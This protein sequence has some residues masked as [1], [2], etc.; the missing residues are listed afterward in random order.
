MTD[1]QV[2]DN[3][4]LWKRVEKTSP[5]STKAAKVNGMQITV[6]DGY[7]MIRKA[8]EQFGPLGIGWGYEVLEE[9]WDEGAPFALKQED[10]T[11]YQVIA[12][13]HTIKLLLWYKHDGQRGEVTQYGHTQALYRSKWGATDDGEA[14]K[15]SLMDAIKKSLSMLGFSADVFTGQFDDAEYREQLLTEEAIDKAEDKEAEIEAK[16]AELTEYVKRN[17]EAINKAVSKPEVAGVVKVSV[18]HLERQKMIPC[19]QQIADRGIKA[20]TRDSQAKLET[21]KDA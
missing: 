20:I 9:R 3:L 11:A 14:P 5:G 15:K 17:I 12:R 6:I 8:T 2:V 21:F 4:A 10:G 13:T 7:G 19:L 1:K 16:Q 18:R